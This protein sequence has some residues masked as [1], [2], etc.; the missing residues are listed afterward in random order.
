M[1]FQAREREIITND[2]FRDDNMIM[3]ELIIR[4]VYILHFVTARICHF[5]TIFLSS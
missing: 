2:H 1:L 3:Y 4:A 5:C